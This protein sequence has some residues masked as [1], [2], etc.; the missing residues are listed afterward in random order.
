ML[1]TR[2]RDAVNTSL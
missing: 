1:Q 2:S